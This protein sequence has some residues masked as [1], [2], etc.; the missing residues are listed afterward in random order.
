MRYLVYAV[1]ALAVWIGCSHDPVVPRTP[2]LTFEKDIQ[3]I[4]QNNCARVGCHNGSGESP[5][6]VSYGDVMGHVKVGDPKGSKLFRIIT[7]L[8]PGVAMPPDGPLADQQ[9]NLIYVWI[10]QGAKEK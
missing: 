6:L 1:L 3:P 2:V 9:I 10:L 7:N 5:T 8:T 4:T